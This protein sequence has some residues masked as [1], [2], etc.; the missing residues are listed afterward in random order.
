MT[1]LEAVKTDE[2]DKAIM[3]PN[4]CH[5]FD[6]MEGD[7]IKL[8]NRE[9]GNYI[10]CRL[11]ES[12]TIPIDKIALGANLM[13]NLG[14]VETDIIEISKYQGE[15]FEVSDILVEYHSEDYDYQSITFDENFRMK[16]INFLGNYH[17]NPKT[18][19]YWPEQNASLTIKIMD[20]LHK[21]GAFILSS[22]TDIVKMKIKPKGTGVPFNAI[23]VIDCSGSMKRQD[24]FFMNM[25]SAINDLINIYS[26]NSQAHSNLLRFLENLK[27]KLVLEPEKY[28]ISR[29]NATFVSILMF[30]N[31]KISRGLGEKCSI[32]LY[33]G[34]FKKFQYNNQ[35]WIFDAR[36][37]TDIDILNELNK[38][39]NNPIELSINQTL[40]TPI[41]GELKKIIEAFSKV[42]QNAILILLLTDGKPEPRKID[43][44]ETIIRELRN[45]MEYAK[46]I[47]KQIVIFTL[48][49]GQ[50]DQVDEDLLT[51][52]AKIGHGEYHFITTFL[53]LTEWFENLANEFSINLLK[54]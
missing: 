21:E 38:S 4:D 45:L 36:D 47:N 8:Y 27:P 54:V 22:Y 7:M 41:F 11:Y 30:F 9:M 44:P 53:E 18:E 48:G 6:L 39:L 15:I 43:P 51:E 52:I 20:D 33:S 23:L 17:L 16:L 31:Q 24:I 10:Y 26:G 13:E 42:S 35:K 32:L 19:L 1:M 49:I 40:F 3:N 25:E 37:F 50:K 34:K 12:E 14:I 28:K 46:R 29:I 2:L 5:S